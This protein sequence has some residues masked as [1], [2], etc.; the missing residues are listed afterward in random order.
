MSQGVPEVHLAITVLRLMLIDQEPVS[1]SEVDTGQDVDHPAQVDGNQHTVATERI[2]VQLL[3]AGTQ[4]QPDSPQGDGS[5][6]LTDA[7]LSPFPTHTKRF[8]VFNAKDIPAQG[9]ILLLQVLRQWT[10]GNHS[11]PGNTYQN[12]QFQRSDEIAFSV[13][14]RHIDEA[15]GIA[16]LSDL[17]TGSSRVVIFLDEEGKLC[18]Y[19]INGAES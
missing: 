6:Q 17:Q 8:G 19:S 7:K 4:K 2:E 12:A 3:T 5:K 9:E 1:H 11:R 18:S 16:Q 10:A 14:F 15:P 13:E